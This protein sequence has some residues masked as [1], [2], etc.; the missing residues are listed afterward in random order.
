MFKFEGI[1]SI[2]AAEGYRGCEVALPLEE[3]QPLSA[4]CYYVDQLEGLIA[5]DEDGCELGV[6]TEVSI[7]RSSGYCTIRSPANEE[8]LVPL[9]RA[10]IHSIDLARGQLTLRSLGKLKDMNR[11]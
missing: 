4:G 9:A 6:I 10:F 5:R 2:E 3:R 11:S 1:D 7:Q 8:I